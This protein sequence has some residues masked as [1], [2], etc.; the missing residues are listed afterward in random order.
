MS[1]INIDNFFDF[2]NHAPVNRIAYSENDAKYKLKC[3][4]AM[5]DLGMKILIDNVGNIVGEFPANYSK[6]RNLV[7]G[8]HTDSVA[9]GGQ[10]DGTVGVYMALKAAESFKNSNNKQYGNLKTIIYACEESTRF[11]TACIGSYYLN[12]KFSEEYLSSL[13]DKSGISFFDAVS[14][15][16]GYIFSHLAE[17][18]I[19]LNNIQLVNKVITPD[20]IS[21]A[22]EAHIEQSE[23]LS[24]SGKSIG[25]VDSIGKPVRGNITVHGPN[26]IVTSARIIND[27]TTLAKESKSNTGEEAVR[28]T[29]PKFNTLDNKENQ[30]PVTGNMFLVSATGENNHSG[31]TPMDARRD[32]VLGLSKLILGLDDFQ[33]QN[34][35]AKIEFLGTVTPKWGAN[36]IQNQTYLIIRVEPETYNP[37]VKAY[38]E[39]LGQKNNVN[40][41]MF[42]LSKTVVPKDLTSE[43]FVD[44][45]QQYPVTPEATKSKVFDIFKNIQDNYSDDADSITFRI[46]SEGKPIKTS[47][48]LLENVKDICDEKKY[49]CQIMHSWPGHDLACILDPDNTTGKRILFF[50]PSQGGSHNPNETTTREAIEIGSDVFTTLAFQRMNKFKEEYKKE[51]VLE[52]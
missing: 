40:F 48:E 4:K 11:S 26:S 32:S 27:L 37:I 14:E 19:D 17:Y 33:K 30:M 18:G 31:A 28:I 42:P 35:E 36:Q 25:I 50:I 39:D 24:S 7:I 44:I 15:Y 49:P 45:R 21:E 3:I 16:K 43:L 1:V 51:A 38:S 2:D 9:N 23:I 41:D 52:K 34:P 12:E 46:T 8:S 29:I 10:F 22:L 6:D 20:E 13:K 5:Q 47:S